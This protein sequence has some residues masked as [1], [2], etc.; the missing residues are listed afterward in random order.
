MKL[1]NRLWRAIAYRVVLWDEPIADM[2]WA[3]VTAYAKGKRHY[4][5]DIGL[6]PDEILVLRDFLQRQHDPYM[7]FCIDHERA[8]NPEFAV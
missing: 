2:I 6:S 7:Q 1:S 8:T 3:K 5:H 4:Q